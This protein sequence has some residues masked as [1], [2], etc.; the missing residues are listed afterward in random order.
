M[1]I[2]TGQTYNVNGSPLVTNATHTGDVTGSGILTI[3]DNAVTLEKMNDVPSGTVFYRKTGGVG[4]PEVQTLDTLKTDL[5]IVPS[6]GG[7]A[8]GFTVDGALAVADDVSP[9]IVITA[10]TIIDSWYFYLD[11]TGFSGS[12]IFDTML[13]GGT[14]IFQDMTYDFRPVIQWV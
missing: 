9:A 7:G 12:S 10:G 5:N 1:N 8:V 6:G 14:S 13:S 3:A 4:N 2:P 11:G